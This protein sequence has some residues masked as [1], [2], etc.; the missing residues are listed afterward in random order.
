MARVRSSSFFVSPETAGSLRAARTA[1]PQF[2]ARPAQHVR[3]LLDVAFRD[4]DDEQ[5]AAQ[6]TNMALRAWAVRLDA[7]QERPLEWRLL[8]SK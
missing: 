1:R 8:L 4:E 7:L 6:A 5:L 3:R 2:Q